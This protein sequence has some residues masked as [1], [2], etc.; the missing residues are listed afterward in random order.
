[1]EGKELNNEDDERDS[2]SNK[3]KEEESEDFGLPDA[4]FDSE[5]EQSDESEES[6]P[7]EYTTG[8]DSTSDAPSEDEPSEEYRPYSQH[9]STR[10]SD[11]KKTP[12]GLIV[13]LSL[14]GIIIIALAVYW[15]FLR[16]PEEP[17][18]QEP[19]V[20]EDVLVI[21][22][23]TMATEPLMKEPSEME[24]AVDEEPVEMQEGIIETISGQTGRYYI[25]L[26][27]FFDGDMAM[28]YAEKLSDQGVNIVILKPDTRRGFNRVA[29]SESFS[30]WSEAESR[31]NELK[32]TYGQ[33]IWIL[34]Y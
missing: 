29:L 6:E 1:M 9:S 23:D 32:N 22:E 18:P 19:V 3:K 4:S 33:N 17:E 28:D 16:S 26:N 11:E 20:Q 10:D 24:E 25:V 15:F 31:L 2:G 5:S 7:Y 27:S 30:S 13:F 34:K 8:A 14:L 12:V 21:P